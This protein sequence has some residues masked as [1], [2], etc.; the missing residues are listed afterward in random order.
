MVAAARLACEQAHERGV[1]AYLD[2]FIGREKGVS[3]PISVD[4]DLVSKNDFILCRIEHKTPDGM[5][6][7]SSI[8]FVDSS[9]NLRSGRNVVVRFA[10]AYCKEQECQKL[11]NEHMQ[12][13]VNG[14]YLPRDAYWT[15]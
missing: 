15:P 4:M 8:V 11:Q 10:G 14:T 3:A 2:K 6:T 9:N 1:S 12:C 13:P 5:H 7:A